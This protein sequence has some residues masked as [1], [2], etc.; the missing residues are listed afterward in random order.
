MRI[1]FYAPLKPPDHPVASG[2]RA[3]AR[4]LIEAF[5]RAGHAVEVVSRFRS[6]DS[7]DALRQQRLRDL[8]ER[9]ADRLAR[10]LEG[11]ESR[12]DV[13]FTYHLYHKAP[14]WLGPP[15]ASRL[16]I[17]YVVTEASYAP[18]Q[19]EGK[20]Q[21]GHDAAGDAIRRADRIFQPNP[22]DAECVLP[23]LRSSER[24]VSLPPFLDTAPLRA[25]DRTV[26]RAALADLYRINPAEPW[27]LAVG[28][29]RDDQKLQS[30]R[31]LG[32]A[33]SQLAD[34]PWRLIVAG[35]GPAEKAVRTA[36]APLEERVYWAGVVAPEGLRQLYRAA[37]L[38]LWPAVKEAWGMALL[39]AQAAGLP[40]VAG[41]SGG[42][43]AI[44]ADGET[45][46]LTPEGDATAFAAAVRTLLD[47]PD[48]RHAMGAQAMERTM[49]HHD[50]SNAAETLDQHLR[51]LT[52]RFR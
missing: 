28:M 31:C 11:R 37:D 25:A 22:A 52:G 42:V 23:L 24:L 33:L 10:R 1:A 29:M 4:A 48:R 49:R 47:D 9:L 20:W 44:V 32:S 34:I 50:I 39:E 18:K 43:P 41:R 2:D 12:P 27:L 51:E 5:G 35:S 3:M 7:G 38:Y 19:A 21:I 36:F 46:L 8:G 6:F 15:I 45:G 17:P 26:C 16:G 30:Y 13:W 40:V 14:D